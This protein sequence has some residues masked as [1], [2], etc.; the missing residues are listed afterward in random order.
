MNSALEKDYE[1]EFALKRSRLRTLVE[2]CSNTLSYLNMCEE[3]SEKRQ[4]D[5][6][7]Y[8]DE[9]VFRQHP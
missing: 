9:G 5:S 2:F 6:V 7:H 4:S 1:L 8:V 3:E